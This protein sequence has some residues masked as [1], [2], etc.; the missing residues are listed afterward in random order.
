MDMKKSTLV[1]VAGAVL[2][3]GL[4]F[5]FRPAQ[6]ITN[7]PP[8]GNIVIAL[9]DSLTSGAG[10]SLGNDYV[11]KISEL[12]GIPIVNKGVAGNTTADALTRLQT[13]VLDQNPD[14]VIVLLGGNDYLKK[15]P[16]SETF[17]NLGSIIS[18]IQSQGAIVVLVGVQ[19][20]IFGDSYKNEFRKLADE[21]GAVYVPNVLNGIVLHTDLMFDAIH[22]NDKG[23]KLIAERIYREL[24]GLLL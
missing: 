12:I 2:L 5:V 18:R 20:G 15:I 6:K 17:K 9:G 7:Y 23:Y 13:D 1:A 10:S 14:I 8:K 22:P 19:G 21:Y 24:E 11:S 16:K 4:F 3:V